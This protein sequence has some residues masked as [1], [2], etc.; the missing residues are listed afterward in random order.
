MGASKFR[1]QKLKIENTLKKQLH[2]RF[3][4]EESLVG[5]FS[6]SDF[7]HVAGNDL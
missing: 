7:L 5:V 4:I 1:K 3:A 6:T 2:Q